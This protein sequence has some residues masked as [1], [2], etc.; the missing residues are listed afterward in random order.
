V[1]AS[2]FGTNVP[3][4]ATYDDQNKLNQP[5]DWTEWP[6]ADDESSATIFLDQ[7]YDAIQ[8]GS[9]VMVQQGSG[10]ELTRQVIPA[11]SVQAEQRTQYGISG[12][13]TEITFARNWRDDEEGDDLGVLRSVLVHA[14][15]EELTLSEEPIES[16]VGG[17]EVTLDGLYE[18]L[19][20]G[21][22]II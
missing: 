16:E 22:W 20:S 1:E 19:T 5:S 2:L 15:S 7:A 21:R 14:Q 3:K 4:M 17:S 18:G 10:G 12:K 6:L 8:A 9:V 13:T 11:A